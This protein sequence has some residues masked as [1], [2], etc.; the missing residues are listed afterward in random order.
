MRILLL[1]ILISPSSYGQDHTLCIPKVED[2]LADLADLHKHLEDHGANEAQIEKAVCKTL[3]PPS[4]EALDS[5]LNEKS[6]GS[7]SEA[8][9]GV[10]FK[11][12]S[13]VLIAAFKKL[14]TAM[15]LYGVFPKE[16]NQKDIQ[17]EYQ[18]NPNCTKVRCALEK[19]WG[20]S[21]S[22]KLLYLNLKHNYN[23]S[24][25]A[26]DKSER[27]SEEELDDVLMGIDDL[28]PHL[29]PTGFENQ[30]LTHFKKGYTLP[31]Y[32]ETTIANAI[33]MLFDPWDNYGH[34]KK[35][36]A[37]FHEVSHNTGSK[38]KD[39]DQS[40]EWLAINSWVKTGDEW[41]AAPGS[42]HPSNYGATNPFEDFSESMS[43][44]R[45][46]PS[47]FKTRCPKKYAFIKDRVFKGTEYTETQFCQSIPKEKIIK[48]QNLAI[49]SIKKNLIPKKY[50]S[51][52]VVEGC[53]GEF[54]YPASEVEI[55]NCTF[56]LMSSEKA[57]E[58]NPI[59]MALKELGLYDSQANQELV[60][61]GLIEMM[62]QDSDLRNK[63]IAEASG[64][65]EAIDSVVEQSIKDVMPKGM[66]NKNIKADDWAWE[67][68][69]E[70]C[71]PKV[72][73]GITQEQFKNCH[74]K[75][76][77]QEDKKN[78]SWGHGHFDAYKPPSIF[79]AEAKDS[80]EM[81]RDEA[82]IT[83]LGQQETTQE[84]MKMIKVK[85]TE[86]LNR[87]HQHISYDLVLLKKWKNETPE[88]FCAQTYG[89][90]SSALSQFGVDKD[91]L[92]PN[93][94]EWC[95]SKQSEQKKRYEFSTDEWNTFV[96]SLI[97]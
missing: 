30:R 19:I 89:K 5:F 91:A 70:T 94:Q 76:I 26:F 83:Y 20:K 18:V 60:R 95:V 4:K 82:L 36:Y 51:K 56:A 23:A 73:D 92:V 34:R 25:L 44:Y 37:I 24:E 72:L 9:H 14:T 7:T 2:P 33:I 90:Y 6:T 54:S 40:P 17:A 61:N 85:V 59:S 21:V 62:A 78:Q 31:M 10:A 74:L 47:D 84:A 35:Q 12:E 86:R 3:V 43:T 57:S 52:E 48:A 65:P 42:C 87:H 75:T 28:P 1:L 39:L 22:E 67:V 46:N 41:T 80:L 32:S 97:K 50:S 88:D 16:E 13:P 8:V 45:Y 11:N 49:A 77:V 81:K 69:Q 63:M 27:F 58:V 96:N 29:T 53:A 64:V 66:G 68:H 15:D 93:I 38:L 79:K 71:L 55:H